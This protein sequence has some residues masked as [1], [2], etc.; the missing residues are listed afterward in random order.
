MNVASELR[1]PRPAHPSED[2]A[3]RLARYRW[4]DG[5]RMQMF[6]AMANSPNAFRDLS[7]ATTC[8]LTGEIVPRSREILILR[9]LALTKA[10][11]EHEL[12]VALFANEVGLSDAEIGALSRCTVL[13]DLFD[14]REKLLVSL[15]E[16][17]VGQHNLTDA[18][19]DGLVTH[20]SPGQLAELL[21][22]ATQYLKVAVL[23]NALR[24]L[25]PKGDEN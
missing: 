11:A 1:L 5:R 12:H 19:W 4:P 9:V 23:N 15:A 18:T 8:C 24:I 22:I 3:A 25:E 21:M 14:G 17:I 20:F 16:E 6:D 7:T 10:E 2:I 13:P